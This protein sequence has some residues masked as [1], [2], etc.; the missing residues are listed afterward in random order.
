MRYIKT[1]GLVL[2]TIEVGE[3]DKI[4]TVFTRKLGKIQILSKGSRRPR[5]KF[6]ACSQLFCYSEFYLYK[7]TDMYVLSNAEVN[8]SFVG[9]GKDL[10]RL[11][12]ATIV[13]DLI[14]KVMENETVNLSLLRLALNTIYLISTQT[15]SP[16]KYL[17]VF[18]IRFLKIAGLNPVLDKCVKCGEKQLS[19]TSMKF[20]TNLG[21][22]ICKNCL[23]SVPDAQNI[24]YD[25]YRAMV[26][27][28]YSIDKNIFNFKMNT[29]VQCEVLML[30]KNFYSHHYDFNFTSFEFLCNM[31]IQ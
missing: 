31:P 27:V 14:L 2:K 26:F 21:G 22:I 19:T 25:E 7:S 29:N 3:A 9:I 23:E 11:S 20:S 1:D 16:V 5:N 17:V 8:N 12:S 15:D 4:L 30:L 24:S 13:A 28:I 6:L 10:E 18:L